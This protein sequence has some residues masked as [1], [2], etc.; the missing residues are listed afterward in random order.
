MH[1]SMPFEDF[2]SPITETN[3]LVLFEPRLCV[4]R[5]D[6]AVAQLAN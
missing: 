4:N 6:L 2:A 3:I 1:Q 5:N